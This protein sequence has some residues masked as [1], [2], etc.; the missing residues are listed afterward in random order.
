MLML[1]FDSSPFKA[2]TR[3]FAKGFSA[4]VMLY[5]RFEAPIAL[6]K[7][8]LV[9]VTSLRGTELSDWE[10]I[11]ADIRSAVQKYEQEAAASAK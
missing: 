10:K 3:G 11:G 1:D 6:P 7:I 9:E 5:G 2:F 4:P 8:P